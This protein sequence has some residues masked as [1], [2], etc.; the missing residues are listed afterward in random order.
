VRDFAELLGVGGRVSSRLAR[1]LRLVDIST[2]ASLVRS[3]I[4]CGTLVSLC[5]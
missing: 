2:R 1:L 3:P 5:A 4:H